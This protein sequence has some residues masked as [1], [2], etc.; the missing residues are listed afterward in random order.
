MQKLVTVSTFGPCGTSI[1]FAYFYVQAHFDWHSKLL[2][3]TNLEFL[4][5]TIIDGIV[6]YG[7]DKRVLGKSQGSLGSL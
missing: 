5:S 1:N 2:I 3:G 7:T 6:V 4:Q